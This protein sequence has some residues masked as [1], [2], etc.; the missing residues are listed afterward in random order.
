MTELSTPIS[1]SYDRLGPPA[2]A[3]MVIAGG[4]GGI[5]RALT[6]A[7]LELDLRVTVLDLARSI[8]AFPPTHGVEA[9]AV[10]ATDDTSV[11]AAFAQLGERHGAIDSLINLVGFR[12][13]LA[14]FDKIS[15]D[16]WD[17]VLAGNLRS[18]VLLCR[19]ATPL[20]LAGGG[21]TIVNVASAMATW[22][23]P[24]HA[25]YAAAKA[26]VLTF[27]RS[28]AIE[29]A[30]LVR[31]NAVAPSAV[32]TD[33]HKGGTGR[34][35]IEDSANDPNIFAA[36]VPMGRIASADDIVGPT[37]FFAGPHSQFVTGQT[38]LVNGGKW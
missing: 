23:A 32:D 33:F 15:M 1:G 4:C 18:A 2:G 12:N 37:L 25:P 29:L 5:G 36:G 30:P 38:L 21:G 16:E 11:G 20:L 17:H 10:D 27:T 34:D 22:A 19:E 3:R 31:A 7:A 9:I 24:Q 26:A 6:A 14:R 28:V 13:Q 8:D 35:T